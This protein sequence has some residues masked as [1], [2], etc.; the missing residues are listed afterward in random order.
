MRLNYSKYYQN[1]EATIET[2]TEE[3]QKMWGSGR[4]PCIGS[5]SFQLASGGLGYRWWPGGPESLGAKGSYHRHLQLL[6][7]ARGPKKM[8]H[9]IEV[10]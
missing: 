6:P 9:F 7:W 3:A 4:S 10:R 5:L 2:N 8:P 1:G